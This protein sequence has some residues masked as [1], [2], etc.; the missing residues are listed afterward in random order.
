[1]IK[2]TGYTPAFYETSSQP[3]KHEVATEEELY[4]LPI[5]K[6]WTGMEGFGGLAVTKDWTLIS[7]SEQGD[8]W[9]V[10]GYISGLAGLPKWKANVPY[11]EL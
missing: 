5:I 2:F 11:K 10:I 3:K 9:H 1:M 8:N 7:V 4:N 6:R